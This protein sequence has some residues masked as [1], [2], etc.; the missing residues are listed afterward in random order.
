MSCL[1]IYMNTGVH[2]FISMVERSQCS[3]HSTISM[4]VMKHLLWSNRT[5]P[6]ELDFHTSY[7]TQKGFIKHPTFDSVVPS[8]VD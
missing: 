3:F 5:P 8:R 4:G 6:G 1:L 2:T 7:S